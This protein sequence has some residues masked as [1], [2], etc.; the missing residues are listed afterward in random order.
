MVRQGKLQVL[1]GVLAHT[2]CEFFPF[3]HDSI[4]KGGAI[5]FKAFGG[6]GNPPTESHPRSDTCSGSEEV[7]VDLVEVTVVILCERF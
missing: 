3:P 2:K 6:F 5:L 7:P 4:Q 1:K